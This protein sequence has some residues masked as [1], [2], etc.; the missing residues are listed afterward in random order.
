MKKLCKA[1]FVLFLAFAAV[2]A[3][4]QQAGNPALTLNKPVYGKEDMISATI[5]FGVI[6]PMYT[7]YV[8]F[9][10]PETGDMENLKLVNASPGKLSTDGSLK[11]LIGLRPVKNDG[12]LTVKPGGKVYAYYYKKDLNG[13]HP[14]KVITKNKGEIAF[15]SADISKLR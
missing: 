2:D 5:T 14:N 10:S 15:T 9:V 11:I 4:A 13:A 1:F 3:A 6:A 7:Q 12:T 8:V